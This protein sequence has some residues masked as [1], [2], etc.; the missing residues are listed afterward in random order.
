[1]QKRVRRHIRQKSHCRKSGE[2]LSFREKSRILYWRAL[3]EGVLV[4]AEEVEPMDGAAAMK[5]FAWLAGDGEKVGSRIKRGTSVFL[6][7]RHAATGAVSVVV[8]G[9]LT[10]PAVYDPVELQGMRNALGDKID[11]LDGQFNRALH[12]ARVA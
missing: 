7:G 4:P 10:S 12:L 2:P 11:L 5:G 9:T 1:M 3:R 6:E 8:V